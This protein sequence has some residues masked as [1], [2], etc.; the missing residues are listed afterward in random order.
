[1]SG[2]PRPEL[3]ATVDWLAENLSRP[4]IRVLDV[5]WR[6]DGTGHALHGA[7]H[8][9]GAGYLDWMVDLVDPD[10]DGPLLLLA[11]P[12]RIAAGGSDPAAD[13]PAVVRALL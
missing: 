10:E 7:G 11:G 3:L 9:P 6:P 12:D 5:R 4:E 13:S 2:Y 1:M 8:V